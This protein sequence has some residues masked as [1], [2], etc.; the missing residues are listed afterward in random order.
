[1]DATALY[2]PT[3]LAAMHHTLG[4]LSTAATLYRT[5]LA[6]APRYVAALHGLA[7]TLYDQAATAAA[8]GLTVRAGV[9]V[10]EALIA[11]DGCVAVTREYRWVLLRELILIAVVSGNFLAMCARCRTVFP[12]QPSRTSGLGLPFWLKA[13]WVQACWAW[14]SWPTAAAWHCRRRAMWPAILL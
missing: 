14:V 1:M 4:E 13:Q 5:V 2:P 10:G 8:E 7:R 9:L 3:R 12:P 6:T 11:L